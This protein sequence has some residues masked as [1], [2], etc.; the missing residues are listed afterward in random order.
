MRGERL[1]KATSADYRFFS[2]FFV[3]TP[4]FIVVGAW[5]L[6]LSKTTNA[7]VLWLVFAGLMLTFSIACYFLAR[8]VPTR[9]SYTIG[10]IIWIAAFWIAWHS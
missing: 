5:V 7:F 3:F 10:A 1:E 6:G 2:G 4:V 8:Y 9:V